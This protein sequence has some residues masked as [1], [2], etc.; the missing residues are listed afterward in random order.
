M[1]AFGPILS[2][3]AG[4]GTILVVIAVAFVWP[5]PRRI[6]ALDKHLR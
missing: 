1:A 2:V 3:V 5:E 6:G 4:I